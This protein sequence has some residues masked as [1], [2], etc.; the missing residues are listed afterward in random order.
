MKEKNY[1]EMTN[2]ECKNEILK[3]Q[4]NILNHIDDHYLLLY[5]LVY[6]IEKEK[7]YI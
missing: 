1:Q 7:E 5:W 2:E 6:L 4:K 3:I